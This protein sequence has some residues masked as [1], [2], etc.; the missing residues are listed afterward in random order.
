MNRRELL[1]WTAAGV[2]SFGGL[3]TLLNES[4]EGPPAL[5]S[6]ELKRRGYTKANK[7]QLIRA[8][9]AQVDLDKIPKG[10]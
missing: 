3:L 1:K 7:S 10:Y 2:L 8:A 6:P 4:R 9:L 5:L